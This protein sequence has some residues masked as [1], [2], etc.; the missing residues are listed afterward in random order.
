MKKKRRKIPSRILS[1]LI[2][3]VFMAQL[4]V[5]L[6]TIA[7]DTSHI[8][9]IPLTAGI[10]QDPI[11]GDFIYTTLDKDKVSS[12]YY[13]TLG[14]TFTRLDGNKKEVKDAAG[15]S[16]YFDVAINENAGKQTSLGNGYSKWE[17][18]IPKDDVYNAMAMASIDWYNSVIN[19]TEP[20]YV[21]VDSII[22]IHNKSKYLSKGFKGWSGR[23]YLDGS[24]YPGSI[25]WRKENWQ[26]IKS[27]EG[28]ADKSVFDSHYNQLMMLVPAGGSTITP[29]SPPT[30]TPVIP[31]PTTEIPP[32]SHTIGKEKPNYL[33][34]NYDPTGKFAIGEKQA[35]GKQPGI[36]TSEL[37]TNGYRAD[38][39]YGYAD[40]E[41]KSVTKK[42]SFTGEFTIQLPSYTQT[43]QSESD[44]NGDGVV[45]S[46]DTKEEMVTPD[47]YTYI[48]GNIIKTESYNTF[49]Y[50]KDVQ[51]YDLDKTQ[52]NNEVYP[53]EDGERAHHYNSLINTPVVCNINNV[54][55]AGPG[56]KAS[57]PQTKDYNL[58]ENEYGDGIHLTLQRLKHVGFLCTFTSKYTRKHIRL[59]NFH[60][61]FTTNH[62]YE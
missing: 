3:A 26:S 36:P 22:A 5:P 49:W 24:P 57:I 54:N 34:Y 58:K 19:L 4:L 42:W 2:I 50:I 17:F 6:G 32:V 62:S 39:W 11:T 21:Q 43:V 47:P 27:A 9:W 61:T 38:Q 1:F 44:E 55:M 56:T 35:A 16:I 37:I 12:I 31:P 41:T 20:Q 14:F 45:D 18:V 7:A 10:R 51:I 40:L 13:K 15:N 52:T 60:K 30:P 29:P 46:N 53:V 23:L 48:P 25:L 28:W 33:T 59:I 8:Q